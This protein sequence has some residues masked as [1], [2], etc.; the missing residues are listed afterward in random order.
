MAK[1]IRARVG[2]RAALQ[3]FLPEQW[4][5]KCSMTDWFSDL[6]KNQSRARAKGSKSLASLVCWTIWRERNARVFEGE[7]K[8][9]QPLL[10]EIADEAAMWAKADRETSCCFS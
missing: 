2:A 6:M 10:S 7:E 3:G 4:R 9:V 5:P 1:E 8:T